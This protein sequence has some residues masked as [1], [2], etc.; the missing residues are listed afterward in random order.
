MR[1][2]ETALWYAVFEYAWALDRLSCLSVAKQAGT[3]TG[4]WSQEEAWQRRKCAR[5]LVR[6][7]AFQAY[8][9]EP[10]CPVGWGYADPAVQALWQKIKARVDQ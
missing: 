6:M 2:L 7:T 5:L 3:V 1:I 8:V 4:D 9:A 10:V